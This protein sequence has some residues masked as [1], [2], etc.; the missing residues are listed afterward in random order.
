MCSLI[1]CLSGLLSTPS[2]TLCAP[3]LLI[4]SFFSIYLSFHL[5][6]PPP[7]PS[8]SLTLPPR[9]CSSEW[10]VCRVLVIQHLSRHPPVGKPDDKTG[11]RADRQTKEE[12]QG[13]KSDSWAAS[14]AILTGRRKGKKIATGWQ[15]SMETAKRVVCQKDKTDCQ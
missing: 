8:L 11:G 6:Q 3:S 5:S 1:L 7:T 13:G 15:M 10:S 12:Q 14:A 9:L 2:L 4:S